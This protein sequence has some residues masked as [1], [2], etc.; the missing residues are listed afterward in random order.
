M[1][2]RYAVRGGGRSLDQMTLPVDLRG[3]GWGQN[4]SARRETL[5]WCLWGSRCDTRVAK[6]KKSVMTQ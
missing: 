6:G 2:M 5:L 3:P 4:R 1:R